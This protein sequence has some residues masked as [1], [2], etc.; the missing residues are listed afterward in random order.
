MGPMILWTNPVK[1]RLSMSPHVIKLAP[2]S[3]DP[4]TIPR[5]PTG[6]L[7]IKPAS[8][9]FALTAT[10]HGTTQ[11]LNAAVA[12]PQLN[13]LSTPSVFASQIWAEGP[14]DTTQS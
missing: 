6:D 11:A 5:S 1:A 14:H 9:C 8:T 3:S 4:V 13:P 7:S 2:T 12:A 10:R